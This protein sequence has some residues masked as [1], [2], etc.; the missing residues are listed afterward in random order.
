MKTKVSI[1][2]KI[3]LCVLL[4]KMEAMN[5]DNVKQVRKY[6][7]R[8]YAI[9]QSSCTVDI[10]EGNT[11]VIYASK[12]DGS[13]I[14]EFKIAFNG[15]I[16]GKQGDGNMYQWIEKTKTWIRILDYNCIAWDIEKYAICYD[17]EDGK[18]KT[19]KFVYFYGTRNT[20]NF[21]LVM[22]GKEKWLEKFPKII[23]IVTQSLA[24]QT[25]KIFEKLA[26]TRENCSR[27]DN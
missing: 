4:G 9:R 13:C 25:S 21:L 12:L 8:L 15:V 11:W 24:N 16:Y 23:S 22:I 19:S 10:R 26:K 17:A 14:Q 20:W 27:F 1:E 5:I 6:D 7:G 18:I 3:S 2:I